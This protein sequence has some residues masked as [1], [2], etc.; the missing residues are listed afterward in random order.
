MGSGKSSVG[1][2]LSDVLT[3]DFIDLD[4][5]IENK[6]AMTIKKIFKTK[7]EIFFRKLETQYLQETIKRPKTV[8]AVGGGTPCYGNNLKS[9]KDQ[10][11]CILIYLKSTIGNLA[12]RLLPE[13]DKRPLIS[14]LETKETLT[15]FIGKHL[16]E[17]APFY[18][19][20]DII[21]TTDHLSIDEVIELIML[22]LF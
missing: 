6:V 11:D 15:E 1:K 4:H 10:E 8:I 2:R 7:G 9:I 13:R 3:Y 17:R 21:I 14:H 18:E 12:D 5:Y 20:S 16:F 22:E 19:Q